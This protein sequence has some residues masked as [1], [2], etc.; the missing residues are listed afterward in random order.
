MNIFRELKDDF[1]NFHLSE[2]FKEK[3]P[4][5]FK[6]FLKRVASKAKNKKED[7]LWIKNSSMKFLGKKMKNY[8]KSV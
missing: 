8:K 2:N 7:F 3:I 1:H 4:Q 5:E 6:K